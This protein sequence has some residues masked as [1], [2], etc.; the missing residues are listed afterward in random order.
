MADDIAAV[1]RSGPHRIFISIT[2]ATSIV[3]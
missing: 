3:P 2:S 1:N